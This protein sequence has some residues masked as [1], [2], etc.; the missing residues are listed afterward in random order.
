MFETMSKYGEQGWNAL[1]TAASGFLGWAASNNIAVER[2]EHVA[3]FEDWDKS[4][5]VYI[6]FPTNVDLER[7]KETGKLQEIETHYRQ[8]LSDAQYPSERFPIRFFFD[9]HENVVKN[10]EGNY[11]YRLR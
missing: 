7:H 9:S 5:E 6:F 1:K 10:Y 8:L 3:T 2:V 11:F 4:S